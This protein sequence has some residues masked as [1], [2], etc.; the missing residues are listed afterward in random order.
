M[1]D[2]RLGGLGE[3]RRRP[4]PL[5]IESGFVVELVGEGDQRRVVRVG[6]A[7]D[8]VVMRVRVGSRGLIR[9]LELLVGV[10]VVVARCG[11]LAAEIRVLLVFALFSS[12]SEVA[13]LVVGE[14]E[15]VVGL[16]GEAGSDHLL[17]VLG[18]VEGELVRILGRERV[19]LIRFG[20]RVVW[21]EPEAPTPRVKAFFWGLEVQVLVGV[22]I[23]IFIV[24]EIG[25]LCF[26]VGAE[27]VPDAPINRLDAHVVLFWTGFQASIFVG[28][29]VV[30]LIVVVVL[31]VFLGLFIL[32]LLFR[33]IVGF[34]VIVGL[35][36]QVLMTLVL[37]LLLRLLFGVAAWL[38][39]CLLFSIV[40]GR[41][42]TGSSICSPIWWM[43]VLGLAL[44][45]LLLFE[46][47]PK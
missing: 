42:W 14:L 25:V 5:E 16:R 15:V 39:S 18:G 24:Q 22:D 27:G 21:V 26:L 30:L 40:F 7:S 3:H 41:L 31:S 12:L 35:L 38:L 34:V 32:L 37:F 11:W 13:F 29:Y 47:F 2:R 20:L 19:L 43:V 45:I 4:E 33:P 9:L 36:V 8:L 10:A 1:V 28:I 23:D 46:L 17:G 44:L 6:V